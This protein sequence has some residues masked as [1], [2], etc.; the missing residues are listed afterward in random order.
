MKSA[1]ATSVVLEQAGE[2]GIHNGGD[3]FQDPWP[4]S[5][6]R[7]EGRGSPGY[8]HGA[9]RLQ[10]AVAVALISEPTVCC[11]TSDTEQR[12][13]PADN[14]LATCWLGESMH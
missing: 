2:K 3:F 7:R 5:S 13:R 14:P 8:L 11:L 12:C 10:A 4:Y 1:H 9:G 6:V